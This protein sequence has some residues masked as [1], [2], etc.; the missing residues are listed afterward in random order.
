MRCNAW[1][2]SAILAASVEAQ[3]VV[4]PQQ[5]VGL[6]GNSATSYPWNPCFNAT[7]AIRSQYFYTRNA[8]LNQSITGPIVI[9]NLR[10][11]ADGGVVSA[12]GLTF[13]NVQVELSTATAGA[14]LAPN[15]IFASNHGPDR[16]VV[17]PSGPVTTLPTTGTSPNGWLCSLPVAP[18]VYDPNAGD[19]CVDITNNPGVPGGP[20]VDQIT[21]LGADGA[22]MWDFTP[23][24]T[25]YNP[26]SGNNQPGLAI[27]MEIGYVPATGYASSATYGSGCYNRPGS[28][29]ENFTSASAFDLNNTSLSMVFNGNGYTVLPG[30]TSFV[31]PSPAAI[32]IANADDT[33]Q[34]VTLGSPLPVMGGTTSALT[35]CSNGFVSTASGNGTFYTPSPGGFLAFTQTCWSNWHDFNPAIGGAIQFEEVGST[36]YV[37]WNAVADYGGAGVST[38]QFQFDRS[39]GMVHMVWQTMSAAGGTGFLTGYKTGTATLD[40]G[41]RDISATLAATFTVGVDQAPLVLTTSARPRLGT[42]INLNTVNCSTAGIGA[43]ILSFTQINPGIS[44][45]PLGMPGCSQYVGLDVVRLFVPAGGSGSSPFVVPNNPAYA[46]LHVFSQSAAF[47]NGVNPLGVLS[48]NGVNLKV[49]QL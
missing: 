39:N 38:F 33:E 41:T 16:T 30:L 23:N 11:R 48:S 34:T 49:D 37:T 7:C 40:P 1:I 26:N 44:L 24:A 3:T 15:S 17:F 20:A 8:F 43:N 5:A 29:Y 46:G 25:V 27:V 9:N 42:S 12:G 28:F 47:V 35:V 14:I 31:A 4:V 10:W 32:T 22:R 19:L 13:T 45:A 21:T 18:F 6:E 36:S 2:V